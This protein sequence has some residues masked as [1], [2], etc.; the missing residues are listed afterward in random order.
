MLS[1]LLDGTVNYQLMRMTFDNLL[2]TRYTEMLLLVHLKNRSEKYRLTTVLKIN[3]DGLA[4]YAKTI[5]STLLKEL[6]KIIP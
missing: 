3:T 1:G 2:F 5:E 6:C 4:S